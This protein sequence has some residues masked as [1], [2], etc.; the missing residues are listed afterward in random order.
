[1]TGL[2]NFILEKKWSILIT[3][4]LLTAFLCF[5]A[6]QI[7]L[8]QRPEDL[9]FK[10]DPEYSLLRAFYAEFGYDE[11]VVVAYSTGD[12]L[13]EESL[14]AIKQIENELTGLQGI[15][16][17]V[18]LR[19]IVDVISHEGSIEIVPLVGSVPQTRAER[20]ALLRRIDENPIYR[21][22]IISKDAASTLF[23]ITLDA[24]LP[25]KDREITLRAI[26]SIFENHQA[27]HPY[28]LSGSPVARA[29]MVRC[30]QRDFSTLFPLGMFLLVTS[31][32]LIFNSY[33]CV[34]LSLLA[35]SLSVVWTVGFIYLV[36]SELNILSV[37]IPSILFIIGTSD[38]V[39]ILSQYQDCRYICGSKRE[40]LLTTIRLMLLPCL[41]TTLTTMVCLSSLG[42]S[43]ILPFQLF[44]IFSAAGVGFAYLLSITIIPIGLSIGDTRALS[45]RKPPSE[46]LFGFLDRLYGLCRNHPF[47]ILVTSL[48]ILC[49]ALYGVTKLHVETDAINFVGNKFKA[50]TDTIHIEEELGGIIP[51]YVMIDSK[52]EDGLKDPALL[53]KIEALTEFIRCQDGVDKVISASDMIKY[54]NFRFHDSDSTYYRIPDHRNQ[55]AE[56]L[57]MASL[58]D[59][60]DT[61]RLFFDDLYKKTPVGIRYRYHDFYR[62]DKINTSLRTYLKEHFS[63]SSAVRAYTTGTAILCANILI[64]IMAGLKESLIVA[65]L[66]TFLVMILLFRSIKI[67]LISMLPNLIPIFMTLGTMGLFGIS[68]NI[69][70]APVAAIALG[71]AIDDTIH[72]LARFKIEFRKDQDYPQAIHRTMRTVG[73]PIV[74]TSIILTVGFCI[75]LFSNFQFTQNLGVL[76]SF[77][78]VSAIFGDLV[79]LPVLLF[80]FKP[81]G[82]IKEKNSEENNPQ[83]TA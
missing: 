15:D 45:F 10:N 35:V 20:E 19:N 64:P 63:D 50:V 38:C 11:V 51:L 46:I 17:I 30:L 41:L 40:A 59:D 21:D 55:V 16:R 49:L 65:A 83:K 36:G 14:D 13:N 6:L 67:A 60:S 75:F 57:L 79:L 34:L 7:E 29:G 62:I 25:D 82:I 77:T 43:S 81:M 74:I 44:G 58:S 32:Y 9:I 31:M 73:K 5:F 72:F 69:G 48:S 66:A 22:L 8:N 42:V 39:H 3:I 1:V 12:V 27:G 2:P 26:E 24:D 4:G 61:L 52:Q 56:L 70:T 76:I 47:S 33:I 54:M 18:T 23:D 37:L 68:L 28:Y 71:V 80:L 53:K 78:V